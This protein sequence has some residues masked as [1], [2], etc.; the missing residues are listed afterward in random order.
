LSV[1][2]TLKRGIFIEYFS[3]FSF[4]KHSDNAHY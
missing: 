3:L 4:W 1:E 2:L